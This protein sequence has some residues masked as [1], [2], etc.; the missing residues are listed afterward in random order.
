MN[1]TIENI[2]ELLLENLFLFKNNQENLIKLLQNVKLIPKERFC[3]VCGRSMP[4]NVNQSL[5]DKYFFNCSK[6][7]KKVSHRKGTF[8]EGSKLSLWTIFALM[9]LEVSDIYMSYEILK[10]QLQIG[11]TS[12]ICDWKNYIRE[13]FTEY[14]C[15][16]S[17]LIGG[18]DVI[19]QIDESQICKRK[20]H[21]GRVLVNQNIWLVGGIDSNGKIFKFSRK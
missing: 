4:I 15:L 12:T 2:D 20:Y 14:F 16:H 17:E 7:K 5:S 3:E 6:C 19:V 1:F 10:K 21:R 8:F 9:Y 13:I 11:S 18:N